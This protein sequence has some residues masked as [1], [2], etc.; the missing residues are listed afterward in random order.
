MKEVCEA[1]V[2][3]TCDKSEVSKTCVKD[4]CRPL[5]SKTCVSH[6]CQPL[7]SATHDSHLGRVECVTFAS[8]A[9]SVNQTLTNP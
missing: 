3:K 8:G 9:V 5:V 2:S 1:E 6:T 4:L 7:V